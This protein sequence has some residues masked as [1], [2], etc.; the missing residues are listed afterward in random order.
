MKSIFVLAIVP[1]IYFFLSL[2]MVNREAHFT[3]Y[4]SQL[5]QVMF[6]WL[7]VAIIEIIFT[8]ERTAHSFYTFIPPLAYF[9]SHYLLLIRRKR[10]AELM[11]WLFMIGLIGMNWAAVNRK[12][13]A[14]NYDSLFMTRPTYSPF[15]KDKKLMVLD[16]QLQ[17]FYN[18]RMAGYF[19]NWDLSKSIFEKPEYFENIILIEQSFQQDPP[20]IIVDKRDL[21]KAVLERIPKL[22]AEY[23]REGINYYKVSN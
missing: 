1:I 2:L 22:Q 20:D 7:L 3:K 18:N 9:I 11:L 10:I 5:L 4:Q 19:L 12:I 15:L 21:M 6:L 17:L 16:N 8:R 23:K 14:I 13:V